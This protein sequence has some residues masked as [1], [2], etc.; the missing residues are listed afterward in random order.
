MTRTTKFIATP[1]PAGKPPHV[2]DV[3][4]DRV[5]RERRTEAVARSK[6]GLV[7]GK[8]TILTSVSGHVGLPAEDELVKLA[9]VGISVEIVRDLSD[10]YDVPKKK[11]QNIL[12]IPGSTVYRREK[13]AGMLTPS[14]TDRAIRLARIFTEAVDLMQGNESEA[15][16]WLN[17]AQE[18]LG[19]ETPLERSSTE[20][21]AREVETLIGRIRHGVFS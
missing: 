1:P 2:G 18:I 14:E 19:G 12:A 17:S 9:R 11:M 16:V 13:S 8:H 4:V 10:L 7:R 21:G 5:V 6:R 20:V 3:S 15:K